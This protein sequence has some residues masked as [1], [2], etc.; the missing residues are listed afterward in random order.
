M[1]ITPI[2][3]PRPIAQPA[4]EPIP[5]PSL[6]GARDGAL[7]VVVWFRPEVALPDD[8]IPC[9]PGTADALF[10]PGVAQRLLITPET[11]WLGRLLPG[12]L[13]AALDETAD[14]GDGGDVVRSTPYSQ[15]FLL[16]LTGGPGVGHVCDVLGA[17]A[18]VRLVYPEPTLTIA[19]A[20]TQYKT[21]PVFIKEQA[22][23]KTPEGINAEPAWA[24]GHTGTG[25]QAGVVDM[26]AT[27]SGL[28]YSPRVV[29]PPASS[30]GAASTSSTMS[31]HARQTTGILGC[32]DNATIGIGAAPE[33]V[34][35]FSA[36]KAMSTAGLTAV[37]D[38]IAALMTNGKLN[39]GD[40][41]NVSLGVTVG[42][43]IKQPYPEYAALLA[44][45]GTAGWP[46]RLITEKVGADT[47]PSG[48]VT[49]LAL[50][51]EP[52]LLKLVADFT[53]KG[54]TVVEAAGNGLVALCQPKGGGKDP[55]WI[56]A[57]LGAN[58]GGPWLAG[59]AKTPLAA[60]R[61]GLA[62]KAS[63]SLDRAAAATFADG[64]GIVV[65]GGQ[66]STKSA[67]MIDNIQL[68]HGN[69]V[70]CYVSTPNA[71]TLGFFGVGGGAH[72]G[73]T[74]LCAPAI[75]GAAAVVQGIAK[76]QFK[77]TFRPA[78]L[79]AL[80]SDPDLG[81]P[82]AAGSPVG[83]MPDLDKLM[84]FLEKP[85]GKRADLLTA[86]QAQQKKSAARAKTA[87]AAPG[88]FAH[89][90]YTTFTRGQGS[91]SWQPLTLA[92]DSDLFTP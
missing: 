28:P 75:A 26:D 35:V 61:R 30:G 83:V 49:A 15:I 69:R 89:D 55:T 18:N 63:H 62:T 57:N 81:T 79:R 14:R 52:T 33:V 84:K 1:A 91:G 92:S 68:N 22:Y 8:E 43:D 88:S 27:F 54:I 80:L 46:H 3:P 71:Q 7:R 11:A 31:T 67:G 53:A 21:N 2:E 41:V 82:T 40:V 5:P 39:A 58:L 64:G 19:A 4:I 66:F 72:I 36:V 51:F 48:V 38:A 20:P 37:T 13:A 87:A 16:R 44:Q 85:Q 70:D 45:D 23:L 17:S 76:A 60:F 6:Q 24:K 59:E 12:P 9:T 74:S 56:V 42:L 77:G 34:L 73:G 50:E 29:P 10:G 47:R 65:A 86:V 78:V 90:P 32:P 25:V